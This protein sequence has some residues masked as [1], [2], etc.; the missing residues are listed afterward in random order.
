MI[1]IWGG[2]RRYVKEEDLIIN[3]RIDNESWI[4]R[5]MKAKM[6]IINLRESF[7]GVKVVGLRGWSKFSPECT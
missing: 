3:R 6:V 2:T 7:L 1:D 5:E 4:A